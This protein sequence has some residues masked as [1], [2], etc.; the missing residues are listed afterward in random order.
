MTGQATVEGTLRLIGLDPAEHAPLL[1]PLVR[2]PGG[3]EGIQTN[4]LFSDRR[5]L[6]VAL[7]AEKAVACH[8]T[9]DLISMEEKAQVE[10]GD[11][12]TARGAGRDVRPLGRWLWKAIEV[13]FPRRRRGPRLADLT[14]DWNRFGIQ[15]VTDHR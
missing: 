10:T 6:P 14:I 1:A 9:A 3:A 7:T 8:E 5:M 12:P 15:A 4:E 11:D 13:S 2:L